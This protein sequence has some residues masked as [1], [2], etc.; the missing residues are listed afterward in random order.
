MRTR[1]RADLWKGAPAYQVVRC[2]RLYLWCSITYRAGDCENDALADEDER[3]ALELWAQW[4]GGG[5]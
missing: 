5:Q 1:T 4:F 2:V 3:F